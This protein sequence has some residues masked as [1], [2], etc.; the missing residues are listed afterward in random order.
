M[1]KKQVIRLTESDLHKVIK[2]SVNNILTE[3]DWKTYANAASAAKDRESIFKD[4]PD[5]PYRP[6]ARHYKNDGSL[7]ME[8]YQRDSDWQVNQS[9]QPDKFRQAAYRE[10]SKEV[11]GEEDF[12]AFIGKYVSEN[13]MDDKMKNMLQQFIEGDKYIKNNQ[14]RWSKR[15]EGKS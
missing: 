1:T 8:K 9:K 5:Y 11:C 12:F 7:D 14:T 15:G 3:L 13:G 2:E 6:M 10:L 4:G